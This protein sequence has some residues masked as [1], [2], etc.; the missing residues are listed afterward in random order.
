MGPLLK[1]R[2]RKQEK[3]AADRHEAAVK[4]LVRSRC[5]TRD[6]YCRIGPQW[7]GTWMSY[8]DGPSEWA[9][10]RSHRRSKTV[11]QVP[12]RRHC[13]QGSLMLCHAHHLFYDAER[14]SILCDDPA[15]GADGPITVRLKQ[16]KSLYRKGE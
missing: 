7:M 2:T 15:L 10:L 13:T 16:P 14:I 3:S 12:E 4:K 8:C 11:N 6:G 5:V 9:H 1:G